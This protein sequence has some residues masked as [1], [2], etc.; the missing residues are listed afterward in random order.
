VEHFD[1]SLA[2]CTHLRHIRELQAVRFLWS[3]LSADPVTAKANI[4]AVPHSPLPAP[5]M[6]SS[7]TDESHHDSLVSESKMLT[8]QHKHV[9]PAGPGNIESVWQLVSQLFP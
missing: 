4:I 9:K 5:G 8:Y 6:R 2:P 3:K 7:F 1:S